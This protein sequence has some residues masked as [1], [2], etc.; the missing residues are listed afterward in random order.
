MA[1]VLFTA[2]GV[3]GVPVGGVALAGPPAEISAS[4]LWPDLQGHLGDEAKALRPLL[5]RL[6]DSQ[7]PLGLWQQKLREGVAKRVPP[8][9]IASALRRMGENLVWAKAALQPCERLSPT[10]VVDLLE[11]TNDILW[12]GAARGLVAQSLAVACGRADPAPAISRAGEAHL[13]LVNRL[14]AT[15]EAAWAFADQ[16]LARDD[17][18]GAVNRIVT[19]FHDVQRKRGA[20]D[21]VLERATNRLRQGAALRTLRNELREQFLNER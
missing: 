5:D 19:V 18:Q 12:S 17:S 11:L 10:E 2:L 20:V 4:E 21:R 13:Y 9:R 6:E 1:V 8:A 7:V 16:L 14:G 15:P 3:G